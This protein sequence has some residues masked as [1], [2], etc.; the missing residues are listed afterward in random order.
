MVRLAVG[1]TSLYQLAPSDGV[2]NAGGAGIDQ[3]ESADVDQIL[4][5]CGLG[6]PCMYAA[7]RGSVKVRR[8]T[9]IVI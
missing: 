6:T 8:I 7:A 3:A 2:E 5:T 9:A 4:V 1:S